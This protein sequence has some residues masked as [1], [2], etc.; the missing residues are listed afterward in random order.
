MP[1]TFSLESL[2]VMR[3]TRGTITR[4]ASIVT[5][6]A[7]IGDAMNFRNMLATVKPTPKMKHT[8]TESFVVFFQ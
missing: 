6:P 8:H 5:A 4:P 1:S 3:L 7:L 2:G